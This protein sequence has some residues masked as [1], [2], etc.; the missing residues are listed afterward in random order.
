MTII[1]RTY[2]HFN[3]VSDEFSDWKT[4]SSSIVVQDMYDLSVNVVSLVYLCFHNLLTLNRALKRLLRKS[5]CGA[6]WSVH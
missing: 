3:P 6:P 1:S 2:V 5:V 4:T